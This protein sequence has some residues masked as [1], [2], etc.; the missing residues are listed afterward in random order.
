MKHPTSGV[1]LLWLTALLNHLA[2]TTQGQTWE[3]VFS[4]EPMENSDALVRKIVVDP[5]AP[6]TAAPSRLFVGMDCRC[7]PEDLLLVSLTDSTSQS[8]SPEPRQGV[9]DI[10]F[11]PSSRNLFALS[12]Y[13]DWNV[14][15]S[16][17][18][19]ATWKVVDTLAS[20]VD[21]AAPSSRNGPRCF[22][23]DDQGNLY[24][25]GTLH[26]S[27]LPD[28]FQWIVRKSG[29][30]GS[31]WQTVHESTGVR[32]GPGI[33]VSSTNGGLFA[34][35]QSSSASWTVRRSRDGGT[36]WQQ[37]D[38]YNPGL[39]VATSIISDPRG[40][41]YVAGHTV[42]VGEPWRWEVRL[43]DNGGNSWKTISPKTATARRKGVVGGIAV[44]P[45]GNLFIAGCLDAWAVAR[46]TPDGVWQQAEFPLGSEY[47]SQASAIAVDAVG[48]V[49]VAGRVW[50]IESG[51]L[52]EGLL[53]QRLGATTLL[54]LEARQ[55]GGGKRGRQVEP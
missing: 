44:D 1:S 53:V 39:S 35:V 19:G 49:F 3:T 11:D 52:A 54:P 29:D 17:D 34:L 43:S 8:R 51:T 27:R 33:F 14:R 7:F 48:N 6:P 32:G 23:R 10:G 4:S 13:G 42:G 46:R 31:S 40:S 47:S 36:S 2:A 45:V 20:L 25:A 18:Q 37:V 28:S 16:M 38:A 22:A 50:S 30:Q 15:R 41:I 55:P 9:F 24:V 5:F 26:T 21:S 12:R